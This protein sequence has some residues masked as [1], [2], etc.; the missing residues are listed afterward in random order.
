[1]YEFQIVKERVKRYKAKSSSEDLSYLKNLIQTNESFVL[2]NLNLFKT[3]DLCVLQEAL[4]LSHFREY[5]KDKP[6]FRNFQRV[7]SG[8]LQEESMNKIVSSAMTHLF[9]E[10]E[11]LGNVKSI[12]QRFNNILRKV[13]EQSD[14]AF[15]IEGMKYILGLEVTNNE[16]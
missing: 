8:S 9:I 15:A 2:D 7:L 3:E 11:K 4:F 6:F 5:S 13:C 1:M 10:F 14:Y 12:F 16:R